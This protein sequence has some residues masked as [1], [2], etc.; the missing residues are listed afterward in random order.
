M[1][2]IMSFILVNFTSDP[3]LFRCLAPC[4]TDATGAKDLTEVSEGG[5]AEL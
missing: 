4:L 2:I 1:A 5:G 3:H